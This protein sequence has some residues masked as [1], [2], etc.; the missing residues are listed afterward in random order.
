MRSAEPEHVRGGEPRFVFV[1]RAVEVL[2]RASRRF[3]ARSQIR[4]QMKL[5][6]KMKLE[7]SS[8]RKRVRPA[9]SRRATSVPSTTARPEVD[10][11]EAAG[12]ISISVVLPEPEGPMIAIHSPSLRRESDTPSSAHTFPKSSLRRFSI[13]TSDAITLPA[14]SRPVLLFPAAPTATPPPARHPPS[15]AVPHGEV[16]PSAR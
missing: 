13:W 7:F 14:R 9:S 15:R 11:S 5:L 4:D 12:E 1:R 3:R 10:E 6:W 16:S 8:A 2:Q